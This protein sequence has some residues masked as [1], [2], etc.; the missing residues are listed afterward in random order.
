MERCFR[1]EFLV[2]PSTMTVI[3]WSATLSWSPSTT[4]LELWAF[5]CCQETAYLVHAQLSPKQ[6]ARERVTCDVLCA[7]NQIIYQLTG[8]RK[9]LWVDGSEIRVRLASYQHTSLWWWSGKRHYLQRIC[10]CHDDAS[11]N[12][13]WDFVCICVPFTTPPLSPSLSSLYCPYAKP[14]LTSSATSVAASLKVNILA[15]GNSKYGS[16]KN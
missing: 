12:L 6:R 9:K 15:M 4:A 7:C 3:W 5:W 2:V 8:T 11:F 13:K 16:T 1:R 14:L 10:W